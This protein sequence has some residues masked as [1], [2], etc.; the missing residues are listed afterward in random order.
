V[1]L[2]DFLDKL[3]EG[4]SA[5]SK[6]ILKDVFSEG[7][8][9]D[10]AGAVEGL[11]DKA[12]KVGET[13]PYKM[14]EPAGPLGTMVLNLTYTFSGWEQHA[15]HQ[16]AVLDFSGDVALKAGAEAP[17]G[18]VSLDHGKASGKVWFDPAMG[19]VIEETDNADVSVNIKAQ[20]QSVSTQMHQSGGNKLMEV[21]ELPK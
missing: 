7:T 11:P 16:C 9:K 12:V 5:E 14:E 19:M 17:E 15:D 6:E 10:T 18:M 1:D 2:Q 4:G 20:G 13:W 3:N 8:L 21:T